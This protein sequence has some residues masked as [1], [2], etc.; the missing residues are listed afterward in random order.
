MGCF[1]DQTGEIGHVEQAREPLRQ[2]RSKMRRFETID[3]GKL[4]IRTKKKVKM[5]RKT[6]RMLMR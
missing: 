6:M 3:I 2:W 4:S 1:G 5:Q